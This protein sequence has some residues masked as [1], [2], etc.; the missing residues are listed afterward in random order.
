MTRDSVPGVEALDHAA[1][2]GILV[3]ADSLPDLFDRAAAGMMALLRADAAPA[4]GETIER[5]IALSAD[6]PA[7]L[8]VQ[9]LRELLYLRQVHGLEYRDARIESLS[10]QRVCARV[11]GTLDARPPMREIKGV[12]YHALDVHRDAD[13]WHARVIFDV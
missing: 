13:G 8:L 5:D 6:D 12:T 3:T 4:D 10:G 7:E 9:W 2:V 1:D 11:R